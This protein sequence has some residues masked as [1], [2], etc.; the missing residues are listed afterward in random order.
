[1][2]NKTVDAISTDALLY[3]ADSTQRIVAVEFVGPDR[4]TSFFRAEDGALRQQE[5][6][7]RPWVLAA[8]Y[9]PWSALRPAPQIAEL[10]GEQPLRYLVTFDIW[11]AWSL[12]TRAA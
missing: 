1:M 11:P 2:V 12:A 4:M 3:G 7:F 9:E 5:E 8:R 10:A 6:P